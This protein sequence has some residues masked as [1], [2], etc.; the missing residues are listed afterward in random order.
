LSARDGGKSRRGRSAGIALSSAERE[1]EKALTASASN[2]DESLRKLLRSSDPFARSLATRRLAERS[3]TEVENWVQSATD[4]VERQESLVAL[5]RAIA[6]QTRSAGQWN[7]LRD[8]V[9]R[10]AL[11][12]ADAGVRLVAITW[13]VEENVESLR[14]AVSASINAGPVTP[15]LLAAHA[16]AL[17]RWRGAGTVVSEGAADSVR[18]ITLHASNPDSVPQALKRLSDPLEPT[19][20]KR[21]ALRVI[22]GRHETNVVEA[23]R[24]QREVIPLVGVR[25]VLSAGQLHLHAIYGKAARGNGRVKLQ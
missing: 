7:A 14:P 22:S 15:L 17:K 2:A 13:V 21:D 19:H 25:R 11:Q 24:H 4:P 8:S 3:P 23:M 9:I 1:V 18:W 20:R 16:E 12:H 10:S 6:L 5:R